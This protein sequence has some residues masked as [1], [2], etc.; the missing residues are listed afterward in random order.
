MKRPW[1]GRLAPLRRSRFARAVALVAGGSALA[2]AL[3]L[4][5]SPVLARLYTPQQV[6]ELGTFL[7]IAGL[8]AVVA[9]L[10]LDAALVVAESDTAARRTFVAAIAVTL[11][12]TAAAG[13]A[14]LV[15]T[16]T[17]P[18]AAWAPSLGFL[19]L[20]VGAVG[21]YNVGLQWLARTTSFAAIARA[22]VVRSFVM[23]GWQLATG[24][25]LTSGTNLIVGYLAGQI[26]A[27]WVAQ[28]T[29]M[30]A[31]R[32]LTTERLR[33]VDVIGLAD[34]HR[35]FTVFGSLQVLANQAHNALPV[36]L[37]GSWFDAA[38]VGYFVMAHRLLIAPISLVSESVR[39]VLY[40]DLARAAAR[41]LLAVRRSVRRLTILLVGP[42]VAAVAGLGLAAPA[43]FATVLGEEWRPAGDWARFL[44]VWLGSMLINVPAATAIPILQMQDW[45][46]RFTAA[47]L[48]AGAVA[49]AIGG[50]QGQATTAI[51]LFA[52]TGAAANVVL[53][54]RVD[55]RLGASSTP[56]RGDS[57]G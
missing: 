26:A 20:A 23:N 45:H 4:L 57:G 54:V 43:A 28:R 13:L 40:P 18:T 32:A 49:F 36:V 12:T 35:Q 1:N 2:Q 7:A 30:R 16:A 41:D 24:A 55:Q 34:R 10:R 17:A 3:T 6:G 5:A 29:A 27:A 48:V 42:V 39:R 21:V 47:Y 37:L 51:A 44:A 38:S 50:A 11:A 9:T 46:L 14:A 52:A 8:V 53:I 56:A 15:V 25:V 33:A 22:N 31:A 19:P